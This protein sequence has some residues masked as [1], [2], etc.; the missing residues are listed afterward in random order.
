MLKVLS[1]KAMTTRNCVRKG[2]TTRQFLPLD[3]ENDPNSVM[4]TGQLLNVRA[5]HTIRM[6]CRSVSIRRNGVCPDS[7]GMCTGKEE[8]ALPCSVTI[9]AK[10]LYPMHTVETLSNSYVWN[11]A[12]F[13]E[14][15]SHCSTQVLPN[16][17]EYQTGQLH[18]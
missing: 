3:I 4:L 1:L 14:S 7:A 15:E 18:S 11:L 17:I 8:E 9:R 13:P 16:Q 2:M 5:C 10:L 12:K 6:N